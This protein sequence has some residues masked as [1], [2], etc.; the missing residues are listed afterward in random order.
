MKKPIFLV[1]ATVAITFVGVGCS[2]PTRTEADY[3]RSVREMI[4]AQVA[5]PTTLTNPSTAIVTGADPDMVNTAINTMRGH[6]AEPADV[7]RDIVLK[8]GGK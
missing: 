8:V 7:K 4:N 1:A 5:D 3:G 6:V 2:N